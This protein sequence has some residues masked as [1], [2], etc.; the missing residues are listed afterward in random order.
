MPVAIPPKLYN[1]EYGEGYGFTIKLMEIGILYWEAHTSDQKRPFR[2]IQWIP[3][4]RNQI[5]R[6][7][8]K[9]ALS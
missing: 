7:P 5:P 3:S 6:E 1:G 4:I 2:A 8:I 9:G